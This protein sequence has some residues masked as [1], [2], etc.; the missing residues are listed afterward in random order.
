MTA[1]GGVFEWGTFT[2]SYVV[3]PGSEENVYART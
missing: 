2:A 3:A 1:D